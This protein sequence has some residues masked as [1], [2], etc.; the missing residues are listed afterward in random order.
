MATT[1]AEK[2][3][4]ELCTEVLELLRQSCGVELNKDG[5]EWCG[6]PAG[7]QGEHRPVS[8]SVEF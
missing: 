8:F 4:G 5:T 3:I 6:A 1:D 2:D 7:H